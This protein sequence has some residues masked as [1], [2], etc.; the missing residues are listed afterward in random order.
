MAAGC[1]IFIKA[2]YN[3]F[4][5]QHIEGLGLGIGLTAVAGALNY[6]MGWLLERQGQRQH[7][8]TLQA[9]GQHLKSDAWSSLGLVIGLGLVM[10]TNLPW[11][12]NVIALGFG[13]FILYTGYRLLRRALAGIMD[14]ADYQL[15]SQLVEFLEEHRKANWI[16]V[17]NLRMITYG[18]DLHIDCHLTLP[19]YLDTRSSHAEVKA[20][21]R[22]IDE[23]TERQ[24]EFFIHADPCEPPDNCRICTKEDC[25]V[26]EL[27]FQQPTV[28]TLTSLMNPR[29]LY[30]HQT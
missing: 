17:H 9:S 11:L 22:L 12:D 15:L 5:P 13:A 19:W 28:W 27:A 7:S 1:T 4:F 20:F 14:E 23:H 29:P 6:G 26:R 30:L 24:V 18:A 10:W 8:L 2:I 3:L 25:P 21:E 16:D